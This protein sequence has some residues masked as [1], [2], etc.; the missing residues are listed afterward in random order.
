MLLGLTELNL[1]VCDVS[2]WLPSE[3]DWVLALDLID[4]EE[5]KSRILKYRRGPNFVARTNVDTK[6]FAIGR[7]FQQL[8]CQRVSTAHKV[9]GHIVKS[10]EGKPFFHL[11]SI[12]PTYYPAHWNYNVSHA[13]SFVCC[14]V[15]TCGLIGVDVMPVELVPASTEV[16]DDTAVRAFFEDFISFFTPKE[17]R[18]ILSGTDPLNKLQRFYHH[19]T[20][21]EAYLKAIGIGLGLELSSFEMVISYTDDLSCFK[22]DWMVISTC[23]SIISTEVCA[24]DWQFWLLQHNSEMSI[25]AVALGPFQAADFCDGGKIL[26]HNCT[27]AG[28][29]YPPPRF[30]HPEFNLSSISAQSL[31]LNFLS[32]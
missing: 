20:L 12:P 5:A 15:S 11:E 22:D 4:D 16:A 1:S 13:G 25:M 8:L 19:W 29:K 7:L 32:M 28:Q 14:G 26:K 17:W 30:S 23:I 9:V 10:V 24:S 21:K 18:S 3:V 27:I 6:C 2:Q 31:I